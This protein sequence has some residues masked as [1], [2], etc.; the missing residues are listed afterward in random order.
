MT[1][2]AAV[3]AVVAAAALGL[4]WPTHPDSGIFAVSGL[5]SPKVLQ[6][7]ARYSSVPKYRESD[8]SQR[9][10]VARE[11][12]RF[13][14]T[15]AAAVVAVA[16]VAAAAVAVIGSTKAKAVPLP[17]LLGWRTAPRSGSVFLLLVFGS[18]DRTSH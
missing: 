6:L 8:R 2:H 17:L 14:K 3:D 1:Y 15:Y 4:C 5:G 13:E 9:M 12:E 16:A 18:G 7:L 10:A 11:D